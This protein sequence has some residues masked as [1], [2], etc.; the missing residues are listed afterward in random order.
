VKVVGRGSGPSVGCWMS[1]ELVTT[2]THRLGGSRLL[3][4]RRN[5]T[6]RV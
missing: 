3:V 2:R 1:L 6:R 4:Q 5:G